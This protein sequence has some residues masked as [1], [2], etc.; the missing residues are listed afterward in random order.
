MKVW[1]AKLVSLLAVA[2]AIAAAVGNAPPAV[3]QPGDCG[4]I[5]HGSLRPE[6]IVSGHIDDC[7]R[8]ES[9]TFQGVRGQALM[10]SMEQTLPPNFA[11]I[12]LDPVL[13]LFGPDSAETPVAQNDD[14]GYGFNSLIQYIL[15]ATGTFRIVATSITDTSGDFQLW[16]SF[17]GLNAT[18]HGTIRAGETVSGRIDATNPEDAWTFE[19]HSGQRVLIAMRR[20]QP[21]T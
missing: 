8:S 3:A 5:E 4:P 18:D 1:R 2:C 19:G 21:L 17:V 12:E 7:H 10:V 13:R 16:Y 6:E 9:W 11:S 14:G 20:A 15:D